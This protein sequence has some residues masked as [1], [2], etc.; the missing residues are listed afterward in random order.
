MNS[1]M[2]EGSAQIQSMMATSYWSP[3][4]K[5]VSANQMIEKLYDEL[6][7]FFRDED[8][9]LELNSQAGRSHILVGLKIRF[10][11]FASQDESM[12][13]R[14][15]FRYP[16]VYGFLLISPFEKSGPKVN[17]AGKYEE[18]QKRIR[19]RN[20]HGDTEHHHPL[21]RIAEQFVPKCRTRSCKQ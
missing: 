18:G 17:P 1:Q 5:P 6:P 11:R 20:H 8:E 4:G 19:G 21:M 9:L 13:Q 14:A 10:H 16:H 15:A 12:L 2:A 7:H 3:D